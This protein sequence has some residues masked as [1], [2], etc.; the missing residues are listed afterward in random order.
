MGMADIAN[1]FRA[2]AEG[3][4]WATEAV[5]ELQVAME[6][7]L[8]GSAV[9][10]VDENDP[11]T[12]EWVRKLRVERPMPSAIRRKATDA[13]VTAR[14]SFDQAA[15][16]A[17]ISLDPT[18]PPKKLYFPWAS[19]PI[20]LDGRLKKH[21]DERLWDTYRAL[22]PYPP[23]GTPKEGEFN[24]K[25]LSEIANDKHSVGLRVQ[26]SVAAMKMPD[27]VVER[28]RGVIR[29]PKWDP[30]TN[31]IELLRMAAGS[32]VRF[33]GPPEVIFTIL[34]MDRRLPDPPPPVV[35][36]LRHFAA[37][38]AEAVTAL[39]SRCEALAS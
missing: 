29:L 32:R 36:A 9:K 28:G 27:I 10:T 35:L 5:D 14:H 22:A 24:I 23:I 15:F 17:H 31:E 21:F 3:A 7:Y 18:A 25:A 33:N 19:D 1:N 34:L 16:A 2:A 12:G 6:R 26:G 20:D 39:R 38:A 8:A 13:L 37:K 30:D 4:E 11:L